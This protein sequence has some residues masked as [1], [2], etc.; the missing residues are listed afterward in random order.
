MTPAMVQE[1]DREQKTAC[2]YKPQGATPLDAVTMFKA[3]HPEYAGSTVSYAGRL[4]PMAEGLLI[5]LIGD[6]NRNRKHY[7][8][9]RK[10]T[11]S[12][13]WPGLRRIRMTCW[14]S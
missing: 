9:L 13:L 7:E 11:N 6:E 10:R 12:G 2:V 4:D 3:R 8:R 1:F 5:L 14:V